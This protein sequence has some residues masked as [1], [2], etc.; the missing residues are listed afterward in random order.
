MPHGA[1]DPQAL[2]GKRVAMLWTKNNGLTQVWYKGTIRRY[3]PATKKH[4]LVYDD[5]DIALYDMQVKS[6]KIFN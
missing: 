4:E 5:G 2:V 3:L 6:I 1:D